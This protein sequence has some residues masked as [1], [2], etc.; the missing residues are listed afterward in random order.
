VCSW[1]EP[2]PE[3]EPQSAPIGSRTA[4]SC[5]QDPWAERILT[6]SSM[7]LRYPGAGRGCG[8]RQSRP[9]FPPAASARIKGGCGAGTDLLLGRTLV[10]EYS[11]GLPSGRVVDT[12]L[13]Q[14]RATSNP[15][16]ATG[17]PRRPDE[18]LPGQALAKYG[19]VA[20][21]PRAMLEE[22]YRPIIA[23]IRQP[24]HGGRPLRSPPV[25]T[26]TPVKPSPS[27]WRS[28]VDSNNHRQD[29]MVAMASR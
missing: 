18:A 24:P 2:D 5:G 23:S 14:R 21:R 11:K 9:Y 28:G 17:T 8:V 3:G 20:G 15:R 25:R 27:C 19:S 10:L 22:T 26:S 6:S 4:S 16:E 12:L 1:P 7:E 13:A 29:G